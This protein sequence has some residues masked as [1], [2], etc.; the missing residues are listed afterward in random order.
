VFGNHI[1]KVSIED[2]L[3]T[4]NAKEIDIFTQLKYFSIQAALDPSI[5]AF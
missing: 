2:V 5:S 4:F 1:G 3:A